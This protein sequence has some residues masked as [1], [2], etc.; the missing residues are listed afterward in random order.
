M[1]LREQFESTGNWLFNRR[2]FFPLLVVPLFVL[3]AREFSYPH[4]SHA[5]DLAW[6][7]VCL[8]VSLF[9]LTIRVLTVAYVPR[10]TSGRNTRKGQV[11]DE[12]NTAGLYSI[13]R[14]PLY[15]GNFFVCL[16]FCL[17]PRVWWFAVVCVLLYVL[18]YERMMFAEE[19]F[20]RRRFGKEYEAWAR[21]T[22]AV[23]PDVRQ[24]RRPS[25]PFSWPTALKREHRTFIFALLVFTAMEIVLD[26]VVGGK[27]AID[28][29]WAG[30]FAFGLSVFV[31]LRV[32]AKHTRVL[33][34]V[35]R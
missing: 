15:A 29:I 23:I 32:L 18:Y 22:P 30:M 35:S 28:R 1:M 4:G 17:F 21:H 34:V 16:G 12:L 7:A 10:R 24:W 2:G 33:R 19:E 31:V 27:L 26:S 6:E 25:L 3:A 5:L 8:C 20:L 13:M 9:G 14:H 11:A